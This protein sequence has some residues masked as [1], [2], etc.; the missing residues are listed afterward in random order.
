VSELHVAELDGRDPPIVLLHHG[1]GSL[2]AWDPFLPELAGGRR[3]LAYD[4]RGYGASPR[5]A[6]FD[7]GLF[8]RDADD[9]SALLRDRDAAPAHLVGFSDGAT[10]A[11]V[12]AVRHP[13]LVVSVTWIGGHIRLDRATHQVLLDRGP[14]V[15]EAQHEGYRER[16]GV[17]WEQ[18]VRGWYD[19]WTREL[20][21]WDIEE[22]LQGIRAPVLVVHDRNDPLAPPEHPEGVLANVPHARVSWYDT[23]SHG[24]HYVERERFDRELE[25]HL[26]EAEAP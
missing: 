23:A 3:V 9:L 15:P 21:D 20:V 2:G 13:E 14:D 19:L 7:A 6:V 17:D 8:E 18:V 11:L 25:E 22:S 5:D 12:T 4:R 24:P 1:M 10:V 16:H 26:S